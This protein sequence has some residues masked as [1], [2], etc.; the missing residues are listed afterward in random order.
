MVLGC[1]F[2]EMPGRRKCKSSL[3]KV[4]LKISLKES[5]KV[6]WNFLPKVFAGKRPEKKSQQKKRNKILLQNF[7]V[8]KSSD[9]EY[10]DIKC[11]SEE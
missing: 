10:K 6:T 4:I 11:V 3:E 7:Q 1:P 8:L 2:P 5:I 9:A